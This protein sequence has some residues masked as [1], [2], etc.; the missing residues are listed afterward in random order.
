MADQENSTTPP[1]VS[2]NNVTKT[3]PGGV[4]ALGGIDVRL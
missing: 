1:V 4:E 2:L 3:F